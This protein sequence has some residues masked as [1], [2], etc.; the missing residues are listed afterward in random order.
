MKK[1]LF[2][3]LVLLL[4]LPTAAQTD[5][6]LE[7]PLLAINTVEQDAIL[8]YDMARATYRELTFGNSDHHVWDF[9]PDGCRILFTLAQGTDLAQLY[10]AKL[11]GSDMQP[12]VTYTEDAPGTWGVW[13]PDWSPQGLIA[14]TMI[15][16]E[17][18]ERVTH[19]GWVP[20][21]G[22][23]PA[24]YSVTGTE[25]T[26]LWSPTGDWL[27]YVSYAERVAG[28]SVFATAV[29]TTEPLPGQTPPTL[30]TLTEADA[31]VVSAD[32]ETKYPLT[33]FPTGNITMPRWSPD[34]DLVGFVFSPS[35]NNDTVWMI[36]AEPNSIP[37]QLSFQWHLVLDL[38]WLPDSTAMIGALRDFRETTPNRLWQVP[39]VGS[40]DESATPYL[41][42]LGINHADY[43]RFSPDGRYL[44]T[45]SGYE[46]LIVDLQTQ[47]TER[48]NERTIGNTP[49]VWSP[50][51][52]AGEAS[53][54]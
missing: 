1:M 5:L 42:D 18:D 38:T 35:G 52:F 16:Y 45:R 26:P 33:N 9:S 4:A 10:S 12:M 28:A 21:S 25:Y 6:P 48:L 31:W 19:I 27:V 2:F 50:Q 17:G 13:E 39:L 14:F 34:G 37:T 47:Q 24:F 20:E 32:G 41:G 44:A 53:C 29:P 15:R 3:I 49:A 40:A 46:L 51:S 36:G 11:D 30:T 43:P 54:D 8:L 7:G 22:G 23:E